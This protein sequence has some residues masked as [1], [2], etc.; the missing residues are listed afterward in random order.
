M[1]ISHTNKYVPIIYCPS[2]NMGTLSPPK[3]S[4]LQ[5]FLLLSVNRAPVVAYESIIA[6]F[7]W[8]QV[9]LYGKRATSPCTQS[10][11]SEPPISTVL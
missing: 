7:C 3:T 1:N 2:L 8:S 5:E 9:P 6:R 10:Q 4:C 11:Y